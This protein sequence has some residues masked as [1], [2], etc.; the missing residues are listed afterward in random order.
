VEQPE[1]DAITAPGNRGL[2]GR[3]PTIGERITT[4]LVL[5]EE[6]KECTIET[7]LA[8]SD[9]ELGLEFLLGKRKPQAA[10]PTLLMTDEAELA[11]G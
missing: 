6:L 8:K 5:V 11:P 3:F 9:L 2:A 7:V 10:L 4:I 1:P